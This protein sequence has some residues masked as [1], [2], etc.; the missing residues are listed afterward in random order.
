MRVAA[1]S[2]CVDEMF[3]VT[4]IDYSGRRTSSCCLRDVT[5]LTIATCCSECFL[6][7]K[8]TTTVELELGIE[9]LVSDLVDLFWALLFYAQ[10]KDLRMFT[11][12]ALN[13]YCVLL[14]F[15]DT[16]VRL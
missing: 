10:R 9:F 2:Y 6:N 15:H 11:V 12:P 8:V 14:N 13:E 3:I 1:V 4:T 7:V 5:E 16:L